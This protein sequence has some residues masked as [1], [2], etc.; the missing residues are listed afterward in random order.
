VEEPPEIQ[1]AKDLKFEKEIRCK[2]IKQLC[3]EE[4]ENCKKIKKFL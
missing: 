2:L 1:R 3:G 4:N